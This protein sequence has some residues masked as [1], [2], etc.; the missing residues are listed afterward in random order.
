MVSLKEEADEVTSHWEIKGTCTIIVMCIYHTCY[1]M[2]IHMYVFVLI[3][4]IA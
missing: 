1:R 2:C 3:S 4:L